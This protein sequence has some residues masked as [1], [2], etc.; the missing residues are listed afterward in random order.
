M[1]SILLLLLFSLVFFFFFSNRFAKLDII[2]I[3]PCL[4]LHMT[5]S[6]VFSELLQAMDCKLWSIVYVFFFVS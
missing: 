6:L 2:A 4:S 3:L 1:F 5:R